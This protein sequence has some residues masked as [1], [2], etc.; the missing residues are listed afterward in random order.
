MIGKQFLRC[1]FVMAGYAPWTMFWNSTSS[2]MTRGVCALDPPL[3]QSLSRSFAAA[4][5]V[6]KFIHACVLLRDQYADLIRSRYPA[7]LVA[8]RATAWMS[9]FPAR[10]QRAKSLV[11]AEGTCVITLA[12][13][14]R[15]VDWPKKRTTVCLAQR[16]LRRSR[17]VPE[18]CKSSHRS[19]RHG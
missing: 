5:V 15:L 11:G 10:F 18:V 8:S 3:T 6:A 17:Q 7:F 19:R 14:I 12:A 4:A 13:K 2:L 1:A 9:F 16:R